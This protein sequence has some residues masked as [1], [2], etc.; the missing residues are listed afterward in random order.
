MSPLFSIVTVTLNCVGQI[1]ETVRSVQTQT[2]TD[3]EY[4]VKD[5][6]STDGT[7]DRL[8]A[9]GV[10]R[11]YSGADAG[12]YDAMNQAIALCQGQFICFMNAG[13]TFASPHILA[14]AAEIIRQHPQQSFF[15]GDLLTLEEHPLYGRGPDGLGRVVRFPDTYTRH[16]LFTD[17]VCQ[18][19][20]FVK[21]RLYEEH[22]L[23]LSLSLNADHEF[24]IHWLTTDPSCA[25]HLP[26]ITAHYAAGGASERQTAALRRQRRQLMQRYLTWFE[27]VMLT[28]RWRIRQLYRLVSHLRGGKQSDSIRR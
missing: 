23:D 8:R 17:S 16:D 4:L 5:G 26:F 6:G 12:I 1:E 28:S 14:Q 15:Y 9:L 20:W 22:P 27:R 21:R 7:I 18:Q 3:Y 2:C 13:D 10:D 25:R 24:F 11:I 19:T